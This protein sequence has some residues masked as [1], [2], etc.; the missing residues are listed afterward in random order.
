VELAALTP[1]KALKSGTTQMMWMPANDAA[2]VVRYQAATKRLRTKEAAAKARAS[3][4]EV[5]GLGDATREPEP[6][7]AAPS[8]ARLDVPGVGGLEPGLTAM[9]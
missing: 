4:Q 1:V 9:T 3:T 2:W 7:E 8:G 5:T 6:I